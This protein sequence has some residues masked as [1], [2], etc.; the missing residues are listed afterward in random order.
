M[1]M[2]GG[3]YLPRNL[4]SLSNKGR[5]VMISF[6]AGRIAE[7]DL[8]KLQNKRA[9]IIGSVLRARS[10]AEKANLNSEFMASFGKEL[11]SGMVKPV[12]DQVFDWKE[13]EAAHQRMSHNDHFG[14]VILKIRP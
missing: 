8:G 2:V 11:L 7:L 14:K 4:D 3:N 5:I 6:I 1:D 10:A 9:R 13:A 12:I